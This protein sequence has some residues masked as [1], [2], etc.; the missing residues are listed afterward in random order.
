MTIPGELLSLARRAQV[1]EEQ[2]ARVRMCANWLAI[3]I[4][5]NALASEVTRLAAQLREALDD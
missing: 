3:A 2:D 5:N 4:E 1:Q